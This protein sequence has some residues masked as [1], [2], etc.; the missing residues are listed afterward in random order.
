MAPPPEDNPDLAKS[1]EDIALALSSHTVIL[2]QIADATDEQASTGS[3]MTKH[4]KKS[5]WNLKRAAKAIPVV[6]KAV[7]VGSQEIVT[8][9]K[10]SMKMQ[11]KALS[12]GLNLTKVM[13]QQSST[14]QNLT[15]GITGYGKALEIG[16]EQ[17]AA[18]SRRSNQATDLLLAQTKITGGNSLKL[19]KEMQGL[20][21]GTLMS[22]EQQTNLHSSVQSLSQRFGMTTEELVGAI[23]ELKGSMKMYSLLNI[24]PEIL[25]A[26]AAIGAALGPEMAKSGTK[27][28]DSMLSAEGAITASIL[29]VSADREA[30]LKGEGDATRNA[31]MMVETAGRAA[32]DMYQSYLQ[33]TGDPAIAYKAVSD[34][35]GPAMAEGAMVYKGMSEA[36]TEMGMTMTDYSAMVAERTAV[37]KEFATTW[38]S[39]KDEAFSP[40]IK[41]IY[42]VMGRVQEFVKA[43][44]QATVIA[45][46][47]V[48]G[49]A[50]LLAGILALK[51]VMIAKGVVGGVGGALRGGAAAAGGMW[52]GAKDALLNPLGKVF[53]KRMGGGGR[54]KGGRGRITKAPSIKDWKSK[55][56][57]FFGGLKKSWK[58]GPTAKSKAVGKVSS[59]SGGGGG[60]GAASKD[61]GSWG[62]SLS[63]MG[64]GLADLGK[65]IGGGIGGLIQNTLTGIAK[66][67]E[68]FSKGKVFKGALGIALVGAS[69][70][71]L[72]IALRMMKGVGF[73][74]ITALALT[75]LFFAKM[76]I[77]PFGTSAIIL[78]AAGLGLV[79]LA[80]IPLALAFS[81]LEG[82]SIG[83]MIAFS[84]AL[85]ILG[86]AAVIAGGLSAAIFLGSLAFLALGTSLIPLAFGFSLLKGVGMDTMFAFAGA[87]VVLSAAATGA[88]FL[89][90]FIMAGASAFAVL[91]LALIPLAVAIAIAA[92]G[93]EQL[94]VVMTA[95]AGVS[96][97]SL[98]LLGPALF[99]VAAGLSA[100]SA[101]GAVSG[102][103]SMFTAGDDPVEKLVK[104]GKAAKHINK[105]V[106]SL[107]KLPSALNATATGLSKLS[108]DDI[109]KM[110]GLAM[111]GPYGRE[112]S[113][114][115][116][117]EDSG[118]DMFGN[119]ISG[120][121]HVPAGTS[122]KGL[123]DNI[124]REQQRKENTDSPRMR[125]EAQET[126]VLLQAIVKAIH[127]ANELSQEN[128]DQGSHGINQR[129]RQIANSR[130]S[131][132]VERRSMGQGAVGNDL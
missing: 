58:E 79:G 47:V 131:P 30:L 120:S 72:A 130:V 112:D 83:Q 9:V 60:G 38:Q 46:R 119:P 20:T 110:G 111:A 1:L 87:L 116:T 27:F 43:H 92:P 122:L 90:P 132:G 127:D 69:L 28:L 13:E 74:T 113:P 57:Q 42:K 49:M 18:G 84:G 7:T 48:I 6:G 17:F 124:A 80:L 118:T 100:L 3:G 104:M 22:N 89:S 114:E 75:L 12:R 34:A 76:G 55:P 99:S 106:D 5:L 52:R 121:T 35:L 40:L 103:F 33:G 77:K 105:L 64:K 25:E 70:I 73:K 21:A 88:A 2:Q 19:M 10:N 41:V 82:I 115:F 62:K 68:A 125:A 86:A 50:A 65:G 53:D 91:G 81:L 11:E 128:N 123:K 32:H 29:G 107:N 108:T 95:L 39:I 61:V 31:L 96:I 15:N 8:A 71:P 97:M 98:F 54:W 44:R 56:G 126:I 109:E 129:N 4:S 66:G 23:G 63:G 93:L 78:G 16:W 67:I 94:A 26:G 36:A 45:V 51:A 85:I 117:I 59:F 24:G 102:F 101:G 14:T 37:S